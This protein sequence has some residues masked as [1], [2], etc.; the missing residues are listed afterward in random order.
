MVSDW[1]PRNCRGF[2]SWLS[3][4]DSLEDRNFSSSAEVN[5]YRLAKDKHQTKITTGEMIEIILLDTL[6]IVCINDI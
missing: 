1:S 6:Q 4:R 2:A 5:V 3:L